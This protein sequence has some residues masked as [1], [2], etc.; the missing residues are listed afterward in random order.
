MMDTDNEN[1]ITLSPH[2]APPFNTAENEFHIRKDAIVDIAGYLLGRAVFDLSD[3]S[4][5]FVPIAKNP[6]RTQH[7]EIAKQIDTLKPIGNGKDFAY[8]DPKHFDLQKAGFRVI[9]FGEGRQSVLLMYAE[10]WHLSFKTVEDAVK[11]VEDFVQT[12][13]NKPDFK[14]PVPTES[15]EEPDGPA[16]A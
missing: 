3:G 7:G 14:L 8:V 16:F 13:Q 1:W 4:R 6:D 11:A 2:A 15:P 5:I 10:D 12:Y 9:D